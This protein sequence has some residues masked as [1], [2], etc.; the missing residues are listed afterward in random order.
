MLPHSV[1]LG[2]L[3]C[4]GV[5]DRVKP[6]ESNSAPQ[7]VSTDNDVR[8]SGILFAF[9]S[10]LSVHNNYF[11][12]MGKKIAD[13]IILELKDKLSGQL[14]NISK[15]TFAELSGAAVPAGNNA[16]EAVSA[17]VVLGFTNAQAQNILIGSYVSVGYGNLLIR[18]L[19]YTGQK[20]NMMYL[21]LVCHRNS[22]MVMEWE[23]TQL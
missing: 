3:A 10:A 2:L 19:T 6:R 9:D 8:T 18:E 17:L 12:L 4:T 11:N 23:P 14:E 16:A 20:R 7:C 5:I 22:I 1:C 15:E 21:Y 13:R